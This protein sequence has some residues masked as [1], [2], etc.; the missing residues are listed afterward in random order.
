[1]Q[2]I[3]VDF[4]TLTS[5]P[6]GLVK[7]PHAGTPPVREGE[8]VVLYDEELEVEATVEPI[9]TAWGETELVARP[10]TAMWHDRIPQVYPLPT[11]GR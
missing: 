9:I 5:A 8:R 11:T 2:R 7:F 10:D 4:N 1:M 3:S 6:A